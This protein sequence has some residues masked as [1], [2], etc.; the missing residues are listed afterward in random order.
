MRIAGHSRISLLSVFYGC[1]FRG[2]ASVGSPSALFND[3]I[4]NQARISDEDFIADV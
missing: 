2:N 4:A 1:R 3:G